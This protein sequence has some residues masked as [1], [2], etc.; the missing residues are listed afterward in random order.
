MAATSSMPPIA[1][2]TEIPATAPELTPLLLSEGE[3]VASGSDDAGVV[4]EAD[5]VGLVGKEVGK[6]DVW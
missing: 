5:E 3:E 4:I 6:E 2:P 1:E